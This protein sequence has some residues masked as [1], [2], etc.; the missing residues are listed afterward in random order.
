M[1]EII[2]CG[3]RTRGTSNYI[4]I[5]KLKKGLS[6]WVQNT[7][8]YLTPV[9]LSEVFGIPNMSDEHL[10]YPYCHKAPQSCYQFAFAS[11]VVP[12][13]TISLSYLSKNT[14]FELKYFFQESLN[15]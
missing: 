8:T 14:Y 15:R 6:I 12:Q 4:V 5:L 3:V 10:R 1:C 13:T 2:H 9:Q 11:K 7:R